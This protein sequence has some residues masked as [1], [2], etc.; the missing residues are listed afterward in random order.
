MMSGD[1]QLS[2]VPGQYYWLFSND[3]DYYVAARLVSGD[4]VVA[5][6]VANGSLPLMFEI[7]ESGKSIRATIDKIVGVIP[8][9]APNILQKSVEDLVSALDISEPAIL[10]N[11][12]KRFKKDEIYSSIGPILVA[13]NPYKTIPG[14]YQA[15]TLSRYSNLNLHDEL[16][17]SYNNPPHIWT[18]ARNSYAQLHSSGRRQAIIISGESGAG[19]TETTKHCLQYLSSVS[20]SSSKHGGHDAIEV[21]VLRTNPLLESF[22]NAKTARNNNSSR[23]GKWL[24]IRFRRLSSSEFGALELI[25]AHITQ[26]LLEKS[27]VVTQATEERNYH[28]FYQMCASSEFGLMPASN[29][30]FLGQAGSVVIPGVD[31]AEE[32][33]ATQQAIADLQFSGK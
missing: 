18:I 1:S 9:P 13:V 31:D 14:L 27:R 2:L 3:H 5:E 26:Y 15:T 10:W 20:L 30:S 28:I 11:I 19:K 4:S 24:E 33:V 7:Y 12:R 23:F 6:A 29:Y 8:H 22:G 32:F 21:K 25:G 16:P 17:S